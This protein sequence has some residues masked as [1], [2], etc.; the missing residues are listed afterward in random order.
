[1]DS[2]RQRLVKRA[3]C[4]KSQRAKRL[5]E[6]VD[7]VQLVYMRTYGRMMLKSCMLYELLAQY[8]C[9]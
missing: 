3:R 6:R 7:F 1:M 9:R 8:N 5:A 2:V 4:A